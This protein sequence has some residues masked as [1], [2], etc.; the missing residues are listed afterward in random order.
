LEISPDFTLKMASGF[1]FLQNF[2]AAQAVLII[3]GE[4]S[5]S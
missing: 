4:L 5:E 1:R 3:G 2:I